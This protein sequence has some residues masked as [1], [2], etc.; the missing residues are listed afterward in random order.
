MTDAAVITLDDSLQ[1][2]KS[3]DVA[4]Q[5]GD[6]IVLRRDLVFAYHLATV[7]DDGQAGI[8][9]VL[10]GCD[11][12]ESTP[13]QIHL[14]NLLGLPTPNYQHIPIIVD[15]HGAKLS[16]QNSAMAIEGLDPALVLFTLLELLQQS[17]PVELINAPVAEIL[18]WAIAHWDASKL[19]GMTAVLEPD[20][21]QQ[22]K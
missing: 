11:L 13:L 19:K 3:W 8:T 22:G 7:V 1:G 4:N 10:R 17:P 5:F 21:L 2:L 20:W 15:R 18:D 14:Q 16:K 9:E 6:F 12:L